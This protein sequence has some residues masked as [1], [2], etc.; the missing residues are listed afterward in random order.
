MIR[1]S[2]VARVRTKTISSPVGDHDASESDSPVPGNVTCVTPDPS[3]SATKMALEPP[4]DICAVNASLAPSNDQAGW[5]ASRSP[6]STRGRGE[7]V[8]VGA[9]TEV[10]R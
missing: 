6:R 1:L 2:P 4:G 7:V 10:F 5:D 8:A 3:P 9:D